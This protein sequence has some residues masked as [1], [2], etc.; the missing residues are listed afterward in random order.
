[1]KLRPPHCG[2]NLHEENCHDQ[3]LS[4]GLDNRMRDADGE[5]RKKRSDTLVRTL[6]KE[7]GLEFAKV[8]RSDAELGT[9]LHNEGL[10]TL[11]QLLR[12]R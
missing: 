11:D 6:R 2:L 10:D 12:K 5:I 1:M 8:H 7:Y 4:P 3:A 9:V